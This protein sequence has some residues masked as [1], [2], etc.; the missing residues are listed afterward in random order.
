MMIRIRT[1]VGI[2]R[3]HVTKEQ[4]NLQDL[5]R[6]L[7]DK[8]E[9]PLDGIV[10]RKDQSILAD[11]SILLETLGVGNGDILD[12]VGKIEKE[13]NQKSFVDERG[14]F[15]KAGAVV[16]KIIPA[17]D[18]VPTPAT[19]VPPSND[20]VNSVNSL[21]AAAQVSVEG[22][23]KESTTTN[24]NLSND[25]EEVRPADKVKKMRI[26][27]FDDEDDDDEDAEV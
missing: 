23:P 19:S 26:D 9:I 15:V 17:D 16:N 13:I 21:D 7:S 2:L 3:V 27:R 14:V 6:A 8:H 1:N 24:Q 20:G 12:L 5:K 25:F 10:L 11:E 4:P 22:A 18:D